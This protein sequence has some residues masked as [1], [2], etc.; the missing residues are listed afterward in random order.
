MV[1]GAK[2]ALE[3]IP[4]VAAGEA[5][6]QSLIGATQAIKRSELRRLSLMAES[7]SGAAGTVAAVLGPKGDLPSDL[8]NGAI[9]W[10]VTRGLMSP[11]ATSR[12]A[13]ALTQPQLRALF[14]QFPRL[15]YAVVHELTRGQ[16]GTA[17]STPIEEPELNSG[18]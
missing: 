10:L 7:L 12:A 18:P 1:S 13:L 8:K 14:Q 15:A 4:G 3:T 17:E 5:R 16:A 11:R 2:D 9:T 6:T